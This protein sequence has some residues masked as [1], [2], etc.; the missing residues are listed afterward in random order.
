MRPAYT[1]RATDGVSLTPTRMRGSATV[2]AL[3]RPEIRLSVTPLP[4]FEKA[5]SVFDGPVI[6]CSCLEKEPREKVNRRN[7]SSGCKH[8]LREI[9]SH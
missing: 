3:Y 2:L 8:K 4:A 1:L 5:H 9:W 7:G 6:V